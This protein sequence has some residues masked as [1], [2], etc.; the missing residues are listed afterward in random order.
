MNIMITGRH[1]EVTESLKEYVFQKFKKIERHA[2]DINKIH[3]ILIIEN[4]HSKQP[5]HTAEAT[6]NTIKGQVVAHCTTKDMYASIHKVVEKM[7][8]QIIDI[9]NKEKETA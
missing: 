9:K 2:S 6:L 7:D 4:K 8:R 5:D 1:I 3:V